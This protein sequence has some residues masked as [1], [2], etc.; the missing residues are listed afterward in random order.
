M[1][2]SSIIEILEPRIAPALVIVNST[3]A[4]YTDTDG[5]LVTVKLSKPGM[6]ADAFLFIPVPANPFGGQ[7]LGQLVVGAFDDPDGLSIRIT[8]TR[9][10]A[11]GDGRKDGDGL[12]NVGLIDAG[13]RG[14]DLRDVLVD[15]DLGAIQAGDFDESTPGLNSLSVGSLG[16]AGLTSGVGERI[17]FI[18]GS[19]GKLTVRGDVMQAAAFVEGDLGSVTIQ[20]SLIGGTDD[21]SGVI[22]T[23]GNLGPVK[24]RGDV[25]GSSGTSSG[26][27]QAGRDLQ[28]VRIGGSIIG[29][30]DTDSGSIQSG[31]FGPGNMGSVKIGGDLVGG[32]IGNGTQ[33]TDSGA[34]IANGRI[35]SVSIGGSVLG[36][37][38]N[39]SGIIRAA[40]Q[41]GAVSIGGD[42][43]GGEGV[44]S[45]RINAQGGIA[46]LSVAGSLSGGQGFGSG[47]ILNA[48]HVGSVTIGGDVIGGESFT[49]EIAA[50][51][52]GVI[53]PLSVRKISIGG[54]LVGGIDTV[55]APNFIATTMSG[56]ILTI[57]DIGKIKIGGDVVGTNSVETGFISAGGNIGKISIG[58]SLLGGTNSRSGMIDS[59]GA[60]ETI[61]IGNDIRGG[62][63]AGEL[64]DSGTIQ[65]GRINSLFVGG[66]IITGTRLGT[67]A[68]LVRNASVH[69][70][71]YIGTIK[72]QGSL[73]G[74]FE[75]PVVI[76][77]R[78]HT[79][80]TNTTDVALKKLTVGGSVEF[81]D[82]ILGYDQSLI[83]RNAD[84]QAGK[85]RVG[86][87][88][89]GSSL[90]A[91]L[92]RGPDLVFGTSDDRKLA[93]TFGSEPVKDAGPISR[94]ASI[95]IGGQVSG[96]GDSFLAFGLGAEHV[97][98]LKINGSTVPLT[99]GASNDTFA[100]GAA[101]PLGVSRSPLTVDQF[102]VHVFE[103]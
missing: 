80:P 96:G 82:I 61:R 91:G 69:A 99:P 8:A 6:N 81:T 89:R 62:S 1:A 27:I 56:A 50:N 26:S 64:D 32:T 88:W 72:V 73:I 97:Q 43:V 44:S 7:Q 25:I 102:A 94:I 11:D 19:L 76:T 103:V 46:K 38:A 66:S 51:F 3:T 24:I 42:V 78:G 41:L 57:G 101:R 35:T 45:A 98:S 54:S 49:G 2:P 13:G 84:A 47:T 100:L 28:S 5:D 92:D 31:V 17:T 33:G 23:Q 85:I 10:D 70:T 87:D 77:A 16:G 60:I 22:L 71:D 4:I 34:I 14:V 58:G 21:N 37:A 20:G 79:N 74:N 63:S 30:S 59:T 12:V 52:T 90:I 48:G 83:G 55:Q 65:A 95:V 15:G 29:G 18:R 67:E 36:G 53:S 86:G 9:Q 39:N 40:T 93:A 75:T 68:D